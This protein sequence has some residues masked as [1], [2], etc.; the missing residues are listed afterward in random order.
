MRKRI[1]LDPDHFVTIA[2]ETHI[3][4]SFSLR[5][6]RSCIFH[7]VMP[8]PRQRDWLR[9]TFNEDLCRGSEPLGSQQPL[10]SDRLSPHRAVGFPSNELR[11]R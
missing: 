6:S 7:T 11:R 8:R 10:A 2:S 4:R 5:P 3:H 1:A 9:L